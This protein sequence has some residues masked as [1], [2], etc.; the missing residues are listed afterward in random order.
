MI[1]VVADT[2][3]ILA[4]ADRTHPDGRAA[5]A[6][7][8]QAGTIIIS[9]MVLDE[10][11]HLARRVAAEARGRIIDGIIADARR[12]R[13]IIPEITPEILYEARS[14]IRRY[15]DLDL[16]LSDAVSVALAAQYRT[17]AVLTLD[18]RDFRTI[19]PL[20]AHKAFRLLPADL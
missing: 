16:D 17:D 4:A 11:D 18:Y 6:A 7:L 19:Q 12:S 5:T 15:A 2:C 10:V 13:V 20:T 8:E 9:P 1:V 3:A 14:V